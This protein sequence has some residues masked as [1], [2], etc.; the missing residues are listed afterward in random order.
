MEYLRTFFKSKE[1]QSLVTLLDGST[2]TDVGVDLR[3][4]HDKAQK[5]IDDAVVSEPPLIYSPRE[6]IL[7]EMML[8]NDN[9]VARFV[10]ALWRC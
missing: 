4:M 5:I 2:Y 7:E 1:G 8:E 9:M 3:P 10:V 6:I